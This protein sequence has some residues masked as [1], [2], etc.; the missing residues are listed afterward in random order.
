MTSETKPSSRG[1][2]VGAVVKVTGGSPELNASFCR[3]V[4]AIRERGY[5]IQV[6]TQPDTP[7]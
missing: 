4:T 7:D 2:H 5:P 3:F 1:D 6:R